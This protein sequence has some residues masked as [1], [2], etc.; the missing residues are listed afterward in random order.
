MANKKQ[1]FST[2]EWNKVTWYSKWGAIILFLLV[3]PV[4]CFYIGTQYQA[5]MDQQS[6]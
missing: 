3:V 1:K 6:Q 4:L 2:L 5:V